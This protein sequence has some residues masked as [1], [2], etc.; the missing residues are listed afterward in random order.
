LLKT[1]EI[2]ERLE[3]IFADGNLDL[4]ALLKKIE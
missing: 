2:M 3:E 1:P 4:E